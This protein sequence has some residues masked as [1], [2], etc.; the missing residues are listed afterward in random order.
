MFDT[1]KS[2]KDRMTKPG[3][4]I[5]DMQCNMLFMAAQLEPNCRGAYLT[6]VTGNPMEAV[7]W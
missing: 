6:V 4:A 3:S 5:E 1:G 2:W 7:H